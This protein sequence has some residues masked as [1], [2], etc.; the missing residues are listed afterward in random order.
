MYLFNRSLK[1]RPERNFIYVWK[2]DQ[3]S[4]RNLPFIHFTWGIGDPTATHDRFK[5]APSI[6]SFRGSGG[7]ENVGGTRRTFTY[8]DVAFECSV[9]TEF[10]ATH[11]YLPWSTSLLFTIWRLPVNRKIGKWWIRHEN[12]DLNGMKH[13]F[14]LKLRWGWIS[15]D[16]FSWGE[17]PPK[18]IDL[19]CFWNRECHIR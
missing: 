15:R 16:I 7:R 14:P 10:S 11:S 9:P 3:I 6:T 18:P 4:C 12:I 13:C 5:F 17:T 2:P 8:S 1:S 19:I